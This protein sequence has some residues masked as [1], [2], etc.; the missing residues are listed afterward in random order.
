MDRLLDKPEVLALTGFSFPTVW[1]MMREGRFPRS[2][3]I[4]KQKV[5]WRESEVLAWLENLPRQ[6]LKGDPEPVRPD[7]V[8][9]VRLEPPKRRPEA[10]GGGVR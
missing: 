2:F 5:A 10:S 8:R 9:R 1:Q 3:L 6:R 7:P 4:G